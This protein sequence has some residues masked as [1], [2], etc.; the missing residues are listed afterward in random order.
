MAEALELTRLLRR[1]GAKSASCQHRSETTLAPRSKIHQPGEDCGGGRRATLDGLS[2]RLLTRCARVSSPRSNV[3]CS[4]ARRFKTQI[5]RAWESSTLSKAGTI[6]I[7]ATR[8]LIIIHDQLRKDLA[9]RKL[10]G[11]PTL[12]TETG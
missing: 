2:R 7:A 6:P 4:T 8:R 5:E 9:N 10:T 12:Y 11:S 1:S 3:N